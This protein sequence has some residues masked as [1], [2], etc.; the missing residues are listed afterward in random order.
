MVVAAKVALRKVPKTLYPGSLHLPKIYEY[1]S[2]V[3]VSMTRG[4]GIGRSLATKLF[5]KTKYAV[6]NKKV[7]KPKRTG[8]VL[9][10]YE[11]TPKP[12]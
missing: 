10:S 7:S 1:H 3:K 4:F 9:K 12:F 11:Q 5:C 8:G 2:R 6:S